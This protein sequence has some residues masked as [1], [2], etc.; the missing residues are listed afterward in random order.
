MLRASRRWGASEP[1]VVRS[2]AL[3]PSAGPGDGAQLPA[4]GD[5]ELDEHLSQMPF[6]GVRADEQLRPDLLI[7]QAFAGEARDLSLLRRQLA[8][9]TDRLLAYLLTRRGELSPCPFGESLRADSGEGL[10]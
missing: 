2:L 9:G 1:L 10:V 8:T 3:E 4:R 5:A 6:D 7:G